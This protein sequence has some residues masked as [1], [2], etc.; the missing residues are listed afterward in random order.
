M[1]H[2][3]GFA[4]C[5]AVI[6]LTGMITATAGLLLI[7]QQDVTALER[8]IKELKEENLALRARLQSYTQAKHAHT[9]ERGNPG[10]WPA[11]TQ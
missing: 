11:V 7:K 10:P 3:T 9:G 2:S 8:R 6:V 5:L 4:L 1:K